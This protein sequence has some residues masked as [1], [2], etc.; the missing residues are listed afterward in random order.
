MLRTYR[1]VIL[2]FLLL[3]IGNR[4]YSQDNRTE[5]RVDFRVNSASIDRGYSQNTVRLSEITSFLQRIEQDS[6]LSIVG[7][8]FCGSASPEGSYQLNQKLARARLETL[9]DIVRSEVEIPDSIITRDD[10][11]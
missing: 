10:R 2:L 7:V 5:I 8:S 1:F 3:C 6:T 11:S 4:A 9:E